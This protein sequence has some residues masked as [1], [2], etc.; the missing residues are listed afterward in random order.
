M[1]S[2]AST[3]FI[4]CDLPPGRYQH[5]QCP[6]SSQQGS[7]AAVGAMPTPI[8]SAAAI[9]TMTTFTF[10]VISLSVMWTPSKG[11]GSSGYF[12]CLSSSSPVFACDGPQAGSRWSARSAARTNDLEADEDP[13]HTPGSGGRGKDVVVQVISLPPM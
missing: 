10:T 1:P 8:P 9:N 11:V 3:F 5:Q 13:P 7:A 2:P 6:A 12:R 4:S